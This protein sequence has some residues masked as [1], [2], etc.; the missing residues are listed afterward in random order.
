MYTIFDPSRLTASVNDWTAS[1]NDWTAYYQQ[2]LE[3]QLTADVTLEEYRENARQQLERDRGAFTGDAP[4]DA[5]ELHERGAI[6]P[7]FDFDAAFS[8]SL[9]STGTTLTM[10][11]IRTGIMRLKASL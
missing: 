4:L 7:L 2:A 9:G 11:I 1:V 5:T 8:D 6:E 3:P 10:D